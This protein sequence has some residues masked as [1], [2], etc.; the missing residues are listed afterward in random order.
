MYDI[1]ELNKKLVPELREIAQEL[2]IKKVE[3]FKK[4][5][6]IYK[7]LDTQAILASEGKLKDSKF[8]E[9]ESVKKPASFEK[10]PNED[11]GYKRKRARI[12]QKREEKVELKK[13]DKK[14]EPEA[15]EKPVADAAPEKQPQ[16]VPVQKPREQAFNPERK[17]FVKRNDSNQAGNKKYENSP[18]PGDRSKGKP[19]NRNDYRDDKSRSDERRQPQQQQYQQ[20]QQQQ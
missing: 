3:K 9:S 1:L 20:Q 15:V 13:F 12:S 14:P 17:E 18:F 6:L 7:I 19:D 5:E 4:Q 16:Q 2:Q 11:Q 10:K 8:S